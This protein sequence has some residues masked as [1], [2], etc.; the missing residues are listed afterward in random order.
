MRYI[1]SKHRQRGAVILTVCFLL[2]FL[3]G[4]MGFALDFSRAFVVKGELQTAM[5]SCALA[6]ARELDLT[7]TAIARAQ[8]AGV[9]A[10]N[11]NRVNFQSASWSDQGQL[12]ATEVTFRDQNYIP[13]TSGT[14]A[15][16]AQCQHTQP[17]V[18]MWLMHAFGAVSGDPA[19]HPSS[20]NVMAL[21]VATRGNAQTT[22]PIPVALKPKLGGVAPNYGFA[23][24]EWIKLLMGPGESTNGEIGW[25]NLDGTNSAAE[26]EDEMNGYC[27]VATGDTLGTPGVQASIVDAWNYRFGI[28]KNTGNPAISYQRPDY[29]GYSYTATNWPSQSNAYGGTTPPMAHATAANFVTKRA[30][31]ASCADMGTQVNGGPASCSGITGLSL[32]SFQKVAPPG[33]TATGGHRQYGMNRRIVIVPVINEGRQVIDYACMLML[34]P[35]SI[36]MAPVWLEF[37]GNA[38]ATGSPCV[39]SGLPGGTGPLVPTLVR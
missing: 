15:V 26:T 29:T 13:T 21:A 2:L 12:T 18:A 19:Q 4:F 34:Q 7:A 31:F 37:V 5:D 33:P 14:A 6:A 20:R 27:G 10:G 22:C 30:S 24:G 11:L 38:G 39:T 8:S 16:Y 36:P 32:N 1:P 23:P 17:N 3:L 9:T 35:L 28:Y 25:A